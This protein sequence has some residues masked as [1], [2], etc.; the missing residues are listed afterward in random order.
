M[1]WSESSSVFPL[2]QS[3]SS[4]SIRH[5]LFESDSWSGEVPKHFYFDDFIRMRHFW[6]KIDDLENFKK[7]EDRLEGQTYFLSSQN[8]EKCRK[9]TERVKIIVQ[10]K[11]NCDFIKNSI[12]RNSPSGTIGHFWPSVKIFR[13][14]LPR[15]LDIRVRVL[16]FSWGTMTIFLNLYPD[17]GKGPYVR[18]IVN[19]SNSADYFIDQSEMFIQNRPIWTLLYDAR[20][21]DGPMPKSSNRFNNRTIWRNNF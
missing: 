6:S 14:V 3:G 11:L 8:A 4:I 21:K 16:E 5:S 10:R 17:S 18:F 19:R 2:G 9:M 1:Y 7:T 12:H 13:P 20:L 15:Y